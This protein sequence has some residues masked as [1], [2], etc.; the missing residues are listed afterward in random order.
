M[1]KST[2]QYEIEWRQRKINEYRG[3]IKSYRSRIDNT[4]TPTINGANT[5]INNFKESNRKYSNMQTKI[6]SVKSE[7]KTAKQHA[8]TAYKFII[9]YYSSDNSANKFI[10]LKNQSTAINNIITLINN[11]IEPAIQNKIAENKGHITYFT[12]MINYTW[13]PERTNK[14][15]EIGRLNGEISVLQYWVNYYKSLL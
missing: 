14:E 8:D 4:L 1:D 6:G 13:K 2:I 12:N 7:L 9:K 3:T 11:K 10:K 5:K 15:A